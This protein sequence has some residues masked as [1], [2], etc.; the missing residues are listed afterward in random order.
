MFEI[1]ELVQNIKLQALDA[2]QF[3]GQSLALPLPRVFG[4]QILAQAV[5][6]AS[7]TV[8]EG[9]VA[10]SLHGYFLRPG[11]TKQEIIY[12]VETVRDGATFTTRRVSA[13]QKQHTI[14][15]AT[16][17]FQTVEQ[18]LEHQIDMPADVPMPET[19]ENDL[20][21]AERLQSRYRHLRAR[22]P[23]AAMD[24]RSVNPRDENNVVAMAPVQGYWVKFNQPI[25]ADSYVHQ[26]LLAYISDL[27]L[28]ST[29]IRPHYPDIDMKRFQGASLDHSLWFHADVRVDDWLYYHMDSPRAGHGRNF[30]RGSFYTREGVLV[31]SSAQEG[32]MRLRQLKATQ[33]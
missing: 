28:M 31:A 20:E 14:F 11:S 17:S 30:S 29:G 1:E 5:S 22:L 10:H 19:L 4:G 6:A 9:R 23:S 32:L 3:R 26:S 33:S 27:S 8:A 21:R 24:F 15:S 7:Q 13:R 12:Q 2:F 18:G 16:L 25:D